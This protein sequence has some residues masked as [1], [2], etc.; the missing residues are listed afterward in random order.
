M[1]ARFFLTVIVLVAGCSNDSGLRLEDPW[2]RP[3]PEVATTA[4]FYLTIENLGDLDDTLVA[5][6]T[7]ACRVT[8]LHQSTMADGVMSM[9]RLADG[10]A[11]PASSTVALEPGGLHVMC[12]DKAAPFAEGDEIELALDFVTADGDTHRETVTA[13]VEDR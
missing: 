5:V 12:I 13:T 4:A 2:A 9:Q 6:T 8:E 7:V 1:R 11:I 10:I 3:S